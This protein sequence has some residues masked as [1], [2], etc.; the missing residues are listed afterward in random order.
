MTILE[1]KPTLLR[2]DIRTLY[3]GNKYFQEPKPLRKPG[4]INLCLILQQ[5]PL[6]HDK[7]RCGC[8]LQPC[9]PAICHP[10]TY[11]SSLSP[12]LCKYLCIG[13]NLYDSQHQSMYPSFCE[14]WRGGGGGRGWWIGGRGAGSERV[15]T[16]VGADANPSG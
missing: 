12:M 4:C 7:L 6:S 15:G 13:K 8:P 14:F 11:C 16:H 1:K 3:G 5:H 9:S 10:S 2:Q